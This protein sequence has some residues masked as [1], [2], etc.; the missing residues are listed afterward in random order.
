MLPSGS[1]NSKDYPDHEDANLIL[2]CY[3]LR[4]EPVLRESRATILGKFQPRSLDELLELTAPGT[5]LNAPF[6]QVHTYWEMVYNFVR[7]G[8]VHGE[9]FVESNN[10]EGIF[11]LA[12]VHP[13]LAGYRER[14][15]PRS[16]MNAEW[17]ATHT[18]IGKALFARSQA[19]VKALLEAK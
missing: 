9:F 6:R 15:G 14:M 16:F 1:R 8:V 5:P 2:R 18:E 3:E 11:L 4:Q 7:A 17:V 10:G 13:F 12:K 19:R